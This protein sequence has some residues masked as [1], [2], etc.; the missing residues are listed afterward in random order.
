MFKNLGVICIFGSCIAFM[1]SFSFFV[2]PA[3]GNYVIRAS[4][5]YFFQCI[6]IAPAFTMITNTTN[7]KQRGY[8]FGILYSFKSIF[9]ITCDYIVAHIVEGGINPKDFLNFQRYKSKIERDPTKTKEYHLLVK[10]TYIVVIFL[11][12]LSV[13]FF[14][15]AAINY[16]KDFK[17]NETVEKQ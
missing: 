11:V 13:V 12:V 3:Y 5:G 8:I 2:I 14:I 9:S 16:E 7:I 1:I 6:W 4:L 10:V 15:L 17:Q